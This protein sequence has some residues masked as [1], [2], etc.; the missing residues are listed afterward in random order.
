VIEEEEKR[1]STIYIITEKELETYIRLHLLLHQKLSEPNHPISSDLWMQYLD[2]LIDEILTLK[3]A[4]LLGEDKINPPEIKDLKSK[5]EAQ[6]P[7]NQNLKN[8]LKALRLSSS[9]FE[10]ILARMVIFEKLGK[11]LAPRIK[12]IRQRIK[13]RIIRRRYHEK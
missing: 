6:M 8:F 12:R 2:Q 5:F 11:L 7:T 10:K 1:R 3:E 4:R 13:I 9:E